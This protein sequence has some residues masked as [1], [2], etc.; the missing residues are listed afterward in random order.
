MKKTCV[1]ASLA[2][3]FSILS[4]DAFATSQAR[5]AL[6]VVD[7]EVKAV[8]MFPV[9]AGFDGGDEFKGQTDTNGLFIMEGKAGFGVARYVLNKTGYY[10]GQG[11][12]ILN[13]GVKD[14][15]YQPWNPVV[16]IVVRRVINPIPMYA[17]HVDA[18]I[19]AEN[20][21]LGFDLKA[22]DW[23]APYGA[24]QQA[25]FVFYFSRRISGD[26]D[27][28]GNLKLVFL[29]P[30][31]GILANH[32]VYPESNFKLPRF[33]SEGNYATNWLYRIGEDPKAGYFGLRQAEIDKSYFL[34]VRSVVDE[35]GKLKEALYGKVAGEIRVGGVARSTGADIIFTYYLNPT[36][37]D[38]NMEFDPKRNL[39]KNLK[40]TEQVNMP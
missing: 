28:E 27:Y 17:K 29:R 6:K 21:D 11:K 12:Y 25:D 38:R 2:L 15:K 8:A 32:E 9:I 34:R 31:D 1:W 16:P 13:G 14:D 36:P 35:N 10:F 26:R 39:M 23:M 24:G 40:S 33:A 5:I 19:P 30:C 37:N 7:D 22:G 4:N 20:T 18:R 3:V